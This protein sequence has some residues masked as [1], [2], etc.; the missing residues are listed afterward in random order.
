MPIKAITKGLKMKK[1]TKNKKLTPELLKALR[2]FSV[3][4]NTIEYIM[5]IDDVPEDFHPV[6]TI[7]NLTIADTKDIREKMTKIDTNDEFEMSDF[8]SEITRNHLVGWTNL[9][10]LSTGEEFECQLDNGVCSQEV[11][12][13]LPTIVKVKIL[14]F[15]YSLSGSM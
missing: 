12:D 7:K 10:D 8:M 5:E 15:I 6:F 9:Y 4:T 3:V 14:Q 11:F 13:L 2:G 1:E